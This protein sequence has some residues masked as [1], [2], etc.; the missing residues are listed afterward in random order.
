MEEKMISVLDDVLASG[1]GGGH[2]NIV[3]ILG[4][5]IFGGTVGARLFQKFRIPQVVGYVF[6]GIVIGPMVLKIVSSEIVESLELFNMFALGIIG[7]MVGGELKKEIFVKFGKQAITILVFEGVS[8]FILVSLLS[9]FIT[10]YFTDLSTAI[11]VGVVFGAICTATDPA[12][13]LQV[14]WEYKCRGALSTMLMAIVALDDALALVLYAIA[15]SVAS[16]FTGMGE[17]SFLAALGH[18]LS[19]IVF[20]LGLGV[21]AGVVLTWILKNT[22]EQD[23]V[24]AFSI[25]SVLLI[26][27][28]SIMFHLDVILAAMALGVTMI[29]AAG[30][31]TKISFD[32]V[33][34]F[35]VPVYV[36]FFVLV[37]ARLH[38][39][40]VSL[41][42]GLLVAAYLIGSIVGKTMGARFGSKFSGG[43]KVITKY[44]GFCLYPQGGIA[45]GLLIAASNRFDSEIAEIIVMVVILCVFV[46]QLLGPFCTKFGMKKAGEIG[47]NITEAD[48]IETYTVKDVLDADVPLIDAGTAMAEILS[49]FA[50]TDA[51]YYPVVDKE[52]HLV[53]AITMDGVRNT[54][55][56]QEVNDW[57]IAMDIM[58]PIIGTTTPDASLSKAIK[59]TED[60][61]IGHLPVVEDGKKL[62]G[63]LNART[64]QRKLSTILLEKQ[65]EADAAAAQV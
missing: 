21:G 5:A 52:K 53:G 33:Q 45:V 3:M 9:F 4:I 39:E 11:A 34:K 31:R 55:V 16:V 40:H 18:A 38:V 48:L 6:V 28:V 7:F 50:K 56:T 35:A 49:I 44:L 15:V 12:S 14:L 41:M 26:I 30:R 17:V 1:V 36:L 62:A 51:F 20:S 47:M 59:M 2:L 10:F 58:E 13:T 60:L 63:V 32:L 42:V 43:S 22:K 54:F 19:E 65:K 57:L 25:S 64:V 27:G 61:D 23:K 46:L 24:L 37:G 8:A 29:N